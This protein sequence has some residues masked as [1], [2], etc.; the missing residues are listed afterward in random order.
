MNVKSANNKTGQTSTFRWGVQILFI[1]VD[2][3][4]HDAGQGCPSC[5]H[6]IFIPTQCCQFF[7]FPTSHSTLRASNNQ[8]R[9]VNKLWKLKSTKKQPR[10]RRFDTVVAAANSAIINDWVP[11]WWRWKKK[12]KMKIKLS[13]SAVG[14]MKNAPH[15]R[16]FPPH[17]IVIR[18]LLRVHDFP[19]VIHAVWRPQ[20][21][22]SPLAACVKMTISVLGA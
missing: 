12:K 6:P 19:G 20:E 16:I 3:F 9:Y 17:G 1:T 15:C 18:C 2:I 11:P 4:T 13:S 22:P 7:F 14:T 5:H 21:I 10:Q 8:H